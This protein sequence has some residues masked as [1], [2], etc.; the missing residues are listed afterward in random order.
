MG[1]L[2]PYSS[3]DEFAP[4]ET[5]PRTKRNFHTDELNPTVFEFDV[6]K[7]VRIEWA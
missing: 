3:I 6:F 4:T 5:R 2:I 1:N 7:S